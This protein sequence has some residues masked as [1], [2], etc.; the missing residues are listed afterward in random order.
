MKIKIILISLLLISCDFYMDSVNITISGLEEGL[1]VVSSNETIKEYVIEQ[2]VNCL[3]LILEKGEFYSATLY[4][5]IGTRLTRFPSGYVFYGKNNHIKLTNKLGIVSEACNR[6]HRNRLKVNKNALDLVMNK[7]LKANDS[8]IYY[9][10]S[11]EECLTG[12]DNISYLKRKK[13][14]EIE[15]LEPFTKWIP[16]NKMFYCWYEGTQSFKEPG[17]KRTY[18][19]EV[20]SSG[21]YIGFIDLN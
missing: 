11:I 15:V 13:T 10:S 18:R 6:V 8:W 20:L 7:I 14:F 21:K 9:S 1:L 3:T 2:G 19:V 16:E 17:T 12:S 5:K 4:R